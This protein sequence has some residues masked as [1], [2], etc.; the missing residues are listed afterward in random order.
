M[1][2]LD[3]YALGAD[4]EMLFDFLFSETDIIAYELSS[5][6]ECDPRSF[7]S[8]SAIQ[9]RYSLGS[10]RAGYLKLWSPSVMDRPV[11]RRVELKMPGSSFRYSVEG[12]GLFQLYL[13]G[14]RDGVIHHTHFGN[15]NE[16]G[17]RSRSMHSADDCDWSALAKLSGRIQRHIRG[18]LASHKLFARPVLHH[19]F[20][21]IGNGQQLWFGPSTHDLKSKDLIPNKS[22]PTAAKD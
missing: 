5:E 2:N 12:A 13:D 1:A 18:N 7:D 17:A 16:A 19:A 9:T 21:A 15:W 8:L 14:V 4:L 3:F 22:R 20:E 11:F 10:Y 6:Y